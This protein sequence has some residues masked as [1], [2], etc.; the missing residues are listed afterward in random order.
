MCR[1]GCGRAGRAWI[2][3]AGPLPRG[4]CCAH[5]PL[6]RRPAC[7]S[8]RWV[9]PSPRSSTSDSFFVDP[10]SLAPSPRSWNCPAHGDQH[11]GRPAPAPSRPVTGQHL[12]CPTSG[13]AIKVS[14]RAH[15]AQSSTAI[16]STDTPSCRSIPEIDRHLGI[17]STEPQYSLI[18]KFGLFVAG[19]SGISAPGLPGGPTRFDH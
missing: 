8:G 18:H 13:R 10:S 16:R 15:L 19:Q 5:P 2:T 1:V 6:A 17:Q 3:G 9:A 12:H 7:V 4:M 14:G 11:Q